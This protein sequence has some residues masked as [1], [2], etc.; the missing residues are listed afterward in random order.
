M[1]CKELSGEFLGDLKSRLD[2]SQ[3]KCG[4][5]IPLPNPE[6]LDQ[7]TLFPGA[8]VDLHILSASFW[9]LTP[10]SLTPVP[11]KVIKVSELGIMSTQPRL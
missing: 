3:H 8:G 7:D 4:S 2:Q 1:L 10:G 6:P 5:G 11:S 9:V